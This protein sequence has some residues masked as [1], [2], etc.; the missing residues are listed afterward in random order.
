[1]IITIIIVSSSIVYNSEMLT[2]KP[3]RQE[4]PEPRAGHE[5]PPQE[6]PAGDR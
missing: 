6:Q 3:R 4:Q 5:V 2:S 1:M